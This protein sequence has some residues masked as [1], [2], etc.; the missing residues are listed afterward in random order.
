MFFKN[1]KWVYLILLIQLSLPNLTQANEKITIG[2][3]AFR[4]I[5][6]VEAQWKPLA[7]YLSTSIQGFE[8]TI[9]PLNYTQLEFSVENKTIDFVFTNSSHF[10]Q[11]AHKTSLSSPLATLI[12]IKNNQPIRSFAGAI[13]VHYDNTDIQ[14]LSDLVGKKI[15]TPSIKSFGGYKM[16]AFELYK[17]GIRVP[18]EIETI[19]TSMPHDKALFAVINGEAD[20]AFVRSGLLESMENQGIIKP[21]QVRV[22]KPTVDSEFP[23]LTS[24]RLYPEWP[25]AAMPHVEEALAGRVTGALLTLTHNSDITKAINIY[26]FRVP[27]DYEPVRQV[28]RT[29]KV[30]PF[31]KV[32]E[33]TFYDL[34]NQRRAEIIG[35]VVM[36]SIIMILAVM[37]L[38]FNRRLKES[39]DELSKNHESLRIAAVAFDTQEAIFITDHNEK[40]IRVNKSFTRITGYSAEEAI[41]QLPCIL[42]SGKQDTSFY[43]EIWVELKA[44]GYWQGEAWNKRKNGETFPVGQTITAIKDE[45]GLV[46]HYLFT[47]DDITVFKENEARINKLA[48]YDPLTGLANRRLLNERLHQARA[49]S[50]RNKDYFALLFIDLDHFKTLNDTLGHDIGDSLLVQVGKRLSESIR[51]CDTV[52]RTGGDE[53]VILLEELAPPRENGAQHA[54]LIA[55]KVLNHLAIPFMLK[56]HKQ[57]ITASIGISLYTDHNETIDE[58]MVRS[59]LAM[60]HAKSSGRNTVSFFDPSMQQAI[61]KRSLLERDLR[62]AIL[63]NE[64]IL[65][66]QPKVD[67]TEHVIG[68]EALIRWQHSQQGLLPPAEFIQVAEECGQ[69]I[70]IGTW[71]LRQ[72]CLQLSLWAQSD[73][74]QHLSIA[75]NI[76]EQQVSQDNFVETIIQAIDEFD[77]P[78]EKL[79]LEITES[80]LM[81]DML[82][83]ISKINQLKEKGISFAIDD[84]GTGYSSLNYLKQLPI[85]WLKIDRSFVHDMLNDTNDE[86][87]VKT[88]IAL[89]KTLGIKLI[90]EGVET[91]AQQEFLIH[92]GCPI[93]QGNLFSKP[94]PLEQLGI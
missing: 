10:V 34:W 57:P 76:S 79:E 92:L 11:L 20:A 50:T 15:A 53:F 55:D 19:E 2:I 74:T 81:K 8:F 85:D 69:I 83:V 77:C 31:D 93:L 33:I 7:D 64:F 22:L 82:E 61:Q 12:N 72:A 84:F 37:I 16:Q 9:K 17:A 70:N 1:T 21:N 35:L 18:E 43:N 67:V 58:M 4:P 46:T 26:G 30:Y 40:I 68:Y 94:L 86:A 75:I 89:S 63:N 42:Q 5:P 90:A 51:E 91:K 14:T 62:N 13:L 39:Y 32:H 80:L 38:A 25:F 23:F 60:Y 44:K 3:L 48:F 65:Y 56:N 6:Q 66:Y 27:A 59:D 52:S 87:I 54:K 88:I 71:V 47:F 73:K 78:P 24:T 49:H 41:G 45:K 29:L 28:L 36:L